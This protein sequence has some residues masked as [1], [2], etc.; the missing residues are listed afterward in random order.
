MTRINITQF[1]SDD[2]RIL[3]VVVDDYKKSPR[4]IAVSK[5][6]P[7]ET[8]VSTYVAK[9]PAEGLPALV[10]TEPGY[11]DCDIYAL[12]LIDGVPTLSQI[13]GLTKRVLNLTTSV[14]TGDYTPITLTKSGMWVVLAGGGGT[15]TT[16][17]K[18][19]GVFQL[20]SDLATTDENVWG[21]M[22]AEWGEGTTHAGRD[23]GTGTGTGTSGTQVIL[24]NF[25]THTPG[26]Y[27]YHAD[28]G[29][30][31]IAFYDYWDDA[32]Q[33]EHWNI[34]IPECP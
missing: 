7:V 15:G 22:I 12:Q 19:M 28:S 18:H 13:T 32:E 3:R 16:Y 26:T 1:S 21:E 33:V 30:N 5:D 20:S 6:N 4:G 8:A 29:D 10:G 34:V 11:A 25:E 9:L 17:Y 2:L 23:P 31:V 27:E 24:H 14:V